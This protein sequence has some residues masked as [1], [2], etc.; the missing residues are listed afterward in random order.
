MQNERYPLLS[1]PKFYITGD[2]EQFT[3]RLQKNKHQIENC[4]NRDI[5]CC[6]FIDWKMYSNLHYND[7]MNT[8][9]Y[10][11]HK[12]KKGIFVR[13]IDN[14]VQLF[15]PFNNKNFVN[16]WSDKIQCDPSRFNHINEMV[17]LCAKQLG[18]FCKPQNI[19]PLSMWY[20]NNFMFRYDK[21][22][23]FHNLQE[24][25]DMLV[26]TCQHHQVPNIEFFINKRDFP[27][28]TKNKTE[29]YHHIY[30]KNH[31]LVSHQ[32]DR[33][34]P[35]LSMV[36]H[37]DYNDIPIPTHECWKHKTNHGKTQ[38]AWEYKKKIAI[39]RG[40][41]TGSG[42]CEKTN[43]RLRL[44]HMAQSCPY[45][46]A[47][48]TKWTNRLKKH[49]DDKF[50]TCVDID[51]MKQLGIYKSRVWVLHFNRYHRGRVL[52]K[53]N[54][55]S[56]IQL[57]HNGL[58]LKHV[59]SYRI[60]SYYHMTKEKQSQYKFIIHIPGNVCA[61]RLT[62]ELSMGCCILLV[63]SEYKM[64]YFHR[65]KPYVHYVPV[66]K[67]LSNL[68]QQIKWCHQ[69]DQKAKMI[70]QQAL[71]F[72]KT[73]LNKMEISRYMSNVLWK[74]SNHIGNYSMN[75]DF[76]KKQKEIESK[77]IQEHYPS[78]P[79]IKFNEHTIIHQNR[80]SKICVIGIDKIAKYHSMSLH[81][82]FIGLF[83][84][85]QINC[86]NFVKTYPNKHME[87]MVV[88]D[89]IR[90]GIIFTDWIQNHFYMELFIQIML[91]IVLA[92][93]MAYHQSKFIHWDL[94]PNNIMITKHD[95]TQTLHY[96]QYKIDTNFTVSII[97]YN[98]SRC[99]VNN[100]LFGQNSVFQEQHENDIRML[101]IKCFDKIKT[102]N[103]EHVDLFRFITKC[104]DIQELKQFLYVER[105]YERLIQERNQQTSANRCVQFLLSNYKSYLDSLHITKIVP[106]TQHA[107]LLSLQIKNKN[108]VLFKDYRIILHQT[109]P[110]YPSYLQCLC[111]IE[112]IISRLD[113]IHMKYHDSILYDACCDK[114]KK[115]C[116]DNIT[117]HPNF[118]TLHHLQDV[119]HDAITDEHILF[120]K[121]NKIQ[122]RDLQQLLYYCKNIHISSSEQ[123]KQMIN[124]HKSEIIRLC[125]V[126]KT[127]AFI[128]S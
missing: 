63:E 39:F 84:V 92:M 43:M 123:C 38:I 15:L 31:P 106:K 67:D 45:I 62:Q 112:N 125:Q 77:L 7:I 12:F 66:K 128:F 51:R 14:R 18:Y 83:C 60:R 48:I 53:Q 49:K 19:K 87:T 124:I 117:S 34:C 98:Q 95:N 113:K 97:D 1:N 120:V 115:Y 72:Y 109:F 42:Q 55:I 59:K 104:T 107:N 2:I 50:V 121:K 40:S 122:D 27:I 86:P 103:Q 111:F 74:S 11:Y 71:Q 64:W 28:L 80:K 25:Y 110:L 82:N 29:P 102:L 96:R 108:D 91:Q 21:N 75:K 23:T 17:Q 46:D 118:I 88:I 58:I 3:T 99:C 54:G 56:Q 4:K 73:Y 101:F 57:E 127:L 79:V 36:Q 26:F 126:Y 70:A 13:I 119:H 116:K 100:L 114:I 69:N 22:E 76:H 85:N 90:D 33:Y 81:E 16:E 52:S 8:F 9:Y 105:K 65:L 68:I 5:K 44:V 89:Y 10:I 32:Y 6:S 37:D 61:F 35:I 94:T 30:G 20:A 47:E 93:D 41:N 78:L 24:L